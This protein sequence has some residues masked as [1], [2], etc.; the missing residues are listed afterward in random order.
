MSTSL[1]AR[2]DAGTPVATLTLEEQTR[3][4][5]EIRETIIATVARTGGHLAPSLGV[6][7]LTIALQAVFPTPRDRIVW[8]VGHQCYAHKLLTGRLERFCTL[9]QSGGIS[10]FPRRSES[11]HDVFG[12]G[13][14]GTSISAAAGLAAARD[15]LGEDHKVVAVIGDG[16]MTSGE[17]FEALNHVGH[18]KQDLVVVLNDNEMSISPN[19]GALSSYLNRVLT[20]HLPT[21]MRDEFVKF[22]RSL[23]GVG[24]QAAKIAKRV[25][26][27]V[28]A[29][30]VPGLL[31][32]ELGF[33]YVGPIPGH[34]LKNLLETFR[35]VRDQFKKP[36]LV[37]VI[38]KKGKGYPPAERDPA[39]YHGV[40]PF[41]PATGALIRAPA[42]PAYTAVFG[43][44]L[45]RE[46][47]REQ[48]LIAITAAMT[49]GTGLAPFAAAHPDRF[50]DV[51]IAEQ[52]AVTFAAGLAC[53]GL[54]PVV[55]VYSTFLQRAFDQVLHDVCLQ[56]LPVVFALDRAGLV[57]DDGATHHGVFDL[58]YLRLMPN[59]VVA[60]P[61]DEA[62]LAR[63]VRTA[64]V[65]TGPMALRYPRGAGV[66]VTVPEDP[67]PLPIGTW[68]TLGPGGDLAILAV[69]SCVFPALEAARELEAEGWR[70]G[71]VNAR[72]VKP[73]DA[74]LLAQTAGANPLLLTAEENV[75]AG[76]FGAAVL[77]HLAT[78]G[79]LAVRVELAGIPDEFVEH[80]TQQALRAKYGLDAAGLAARARRMLEDKRDGR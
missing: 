59:L 7:E 60:A 25:E 75:L 2:I 52:H 6:V 28:K 4:A 23:P 41:D 27:S 45:V 57:G 19:V 3:L 29:L 30:I 80:G 13:H 63:L 77:E 9:R 38:T 79:P 16:S 11:C 1:L 62:E 10:G 37:H 17:A 21:R 26:E 35:N 66:G 50:F 32:E 69:G 24:E 71:V 51:G 8:D 47:D 67:E 43:Q 78:H 74:Q 56:G 61:K 70:V 58:S 18:L 39:R 5:A 20:G 40:G 68:E 73:L 64:L 12:T 55:A 54:R 65:H 31:F 48:R 53:E 33:R 15:A 44:A 34:E 49:D 76:G 22:I 36:V 46:A 42:P 14:S 72:F